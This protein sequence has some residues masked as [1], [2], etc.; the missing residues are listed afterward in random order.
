MY[1]QAAQ[2]YQKASKA[3]ANPRELEASLLM[4]AAARMQALVDEWEPDGATLDEAV[5]YNRRLW[6][7]L[8]TSATKSDN[9]LPD[10]IKQNMANLGLYVFKTSIGTLAEPKPE[11][12]NSLISI[13]RNIA[14]GLRSRAA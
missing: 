9:P 13:N 3:A 4:K 5:S 2:A 11:K 8:V 12:L 6:T 10:E 7:I 14:E 1:N